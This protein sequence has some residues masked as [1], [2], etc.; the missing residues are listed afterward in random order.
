MP[1]S[2]H[3]RSFVLGAIVL[4]FTG[5]VSGF[6]ETET[7]PPQVFVPPTVDLGEPLS[8]DKQSRDASI[9]G[10]DRV[11]GSV[12]GHP[13]FLSDLARASRALPE[14]MRNLPFET[15]MPVLLD[16][17]IDHMALTMTARRAG[18]DKNPDVRREIDAATDLVL[19]SAWLAR[20]AAPKVTEEA[21][22]QRYNEEYANRPATE[23]VRAR[24]IL[25]GSEAEA[26]K[27]LAEL[28]RGA[29][30]ATIA[31]LVSKDPD[32]R[33]GGDLGFFRRDQVWA[34]FAD[35]AFSLQPGEVNPQ[36][37]HNEFGWHVVKVEEKRLVA[38][39][40]LSESREEIRKEL[41]AR[42]VTLAIKDARSRMIVRKFNMDGTELDPLAF[43]KENEAPVR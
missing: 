2:T 1:L 27:V 14:A 11:I 3:L 21:I 17:M 40:T 12:D 41:T 33:N 39:P 42:A 37:I 36:P 26:R 15:V 38:P 19:E 24:H 23:E 32:G 6:A 7:P 43:R 30:F 22:Q 20:T 16:R 5:P 8:S 10:G 34:E 31:R 4:A 35:V 25:V 28:G 29:D 18:L 9:A 13:I